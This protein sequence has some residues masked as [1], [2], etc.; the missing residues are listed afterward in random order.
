MRQ[1]LSRVSIGV[2][3]NCSFLLHTIYYMS[4]KGARSSLVE[5]NAMFCITL[6]LFLE[7]GQRVTHLSSYVT[8]LLA[9]CYPNLIANYEIYFFEDFL[10]WLCFSVCYD[11]NSS[12]RFI[13]RLYNS[14]LFDACVPIVTERQMWKNRCW[15]RC[16]RSPPIKY[17]Y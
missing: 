2:Y 9:P 8:V 7:R 17:R 5:W 16:N 4:S 1:I 15:R 13:D 10:R 11:T 12:S 14:A 6:L 3:L